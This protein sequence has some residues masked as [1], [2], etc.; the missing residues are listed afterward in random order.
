LY[1]IGLSP[2]RLTD[3]VFFVGVYIT[4]SFFFSIKSWVVTVNYLRLDWLTL[5][6]SHGIVAFVLNVGLPE[7]WQLQ[8]VWVFPLCLFSPIMVDESESIHFNTH[9]MI[10]QKRVRSC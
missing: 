3:D 7:E 9:A 6:A 8:Q 5:A 4:T 10:G 1:K 2:W